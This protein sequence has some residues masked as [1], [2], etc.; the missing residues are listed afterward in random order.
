[1]QGLFHQDNAPAHKAEVAMTA[2]QE[3]VFEL[4]E[5]L[6]YP[7]LTSCDFYLFPRLKEQLRG[8]KF[9]DIVK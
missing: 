1:M 9:K 4:L 2:I 3:T 8:R 7:N 6:A 5:H